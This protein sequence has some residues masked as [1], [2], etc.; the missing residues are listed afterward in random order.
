LNATAYGIREVTMRATQLALAALLVVAVPAFAQRGESRN[1]DG[2]RG[3][4][5]SQQH[6]ASV[7]QVRPT[8]ENPVAQPQPRN[9]DRNFSERNVNSSAGKDRYVAGGTGRADVRY[10]DRTTWQSS[11]TNRDYARDNRE[12]ARESERYEGGFGRDHVWRLMGGDPSR[13]FFSGYA[14]S[15]APYDMQ[16]CGGW[17][18][19][20]D[21]IAIYQDPDN[22]GGYLAYNMRLGVYVHVLFLG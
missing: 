19:D 17:R 14:F 9:N 3:A 10:N 7:H 8:R 11:D 20:S 5:S 16:Y 21:D 15:V 22:A 2:N 12:D 13:F 4:W 18:W 1:Q 6:V